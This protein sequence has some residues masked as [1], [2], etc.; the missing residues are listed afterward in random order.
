LA[1]AWQGTSRAEKSA[2]AARK[3]DDANVVFEGG[4]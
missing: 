2:A 4:T 3:L 1:Y